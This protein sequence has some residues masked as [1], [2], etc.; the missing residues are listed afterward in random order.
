MSLIHLAVLSSLTWAHHLFMIHVPYDTVHL[1]SSVSV[2]ISLSTVHKFML[3]VSSVSM[4]ATMCYVFVLWAHLLVSVLGGISG[5]Y[6]AICS[7][8]ES[9]HGVSVVYYHFHFILSFSWVVVMLLCVISINDND[10]LLCSANML[11][12]MISLFTVSTL[13]ARRVSVWLSD[14]ATWHSSSGGYVLIWLKLTM[15]DLLMTD[16]SPSWSTLYY[17]Y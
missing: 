2:C 10:K 16:S 3:L 1:F 17:S 12:L 8:N 5:L 13:N 11:Y 6:M 7:V 4:H 14:D 9:V 15:T